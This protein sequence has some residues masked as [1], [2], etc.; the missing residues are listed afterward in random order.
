MDLLINLLLRAIF[1]TLGAAAGVWLLRWMRANWSTAEERWTVRIA[2]GM[3]VLTG[4]YIVSH[5]RLLAQRESIQEGRERYAVFGDPRRTELRR[6]EVRGWML[7]CSGEQ[8]RALALYRE[9]DGVVQRAY[10]LG[11][12]GA[13][14]IGGGTGAE[15]RDFT[16]ELLYTA[17][18]R[19]P[20]TFLERGELHP[21]GT[22]LHL[23]MCRGAT[24]EAHQALVQSGRA[25]AVVVQDVRTGAVI[26]YAATGGPEEAP[27]GI[28]RYFAP[29]SV[30]KLALA[31]VWWD[32]GLGDG[33]VP[34]P[35]EIQ[36]SPRAVIANA[37]RVD[38]GIL[39]GPT[40]MLIPSC[41]T[42]AVWMAMQ[43][44]ERLG[45]E[46]LV[47]GYRRFGFIPYEADPPTGADPDF[48]RTSSSAWAR[49]MG[50]SPARIRMSENTGPAEWG[51]LA[52]GQGPIDLTVISV[53]RFIQAIGNGGVMLPPTLETDYAADP[54]RGERVMSEQTAQR[55]QNAMRLTVEQ[56]TARAALPI[57]QG[58]G[59]RMGGKTGTAQVAGRPD[60]GWFA[61]LVFSPEGVPRY[62]V[63]TFLEAGGAGGGLP[64]TIAARVARQLTQQPPLAWEV[65]R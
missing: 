17:Q 19:Q 25:G 41:N 18:L 1:L 4:F 28:R 26:A 57:M 10:P 46:A 54:P 27:L 56:G 39:Q 34:C 13:N 37:G 59:W 2:A 52:I 38:R 3:L 47:E 31:A 15:D 44:R 14:F 58:T 55:L 22:D 12:A 35:A 7:D 65:E 21:V 48:W 16:I 45:S 40:G 63:V 61:A 9:S 43:M 42:G 29:G 23:T 49:R 60:N 51:Q 6:A 64:T 5:S 62:S 30:F 32:N 11:E 20:R 33:P 24:A 36:I 50:P 8:E 53:S